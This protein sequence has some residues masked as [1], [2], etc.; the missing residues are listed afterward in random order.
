MEISYHLF[1]PAP[2]KVANNIDF[3]V[4]FG[5]LQEK[6]LILSVHWKWIVVNVFLHTQFS[7]MHCFPIY[8]H[9]CPTCISSFTFQT[10]KILFFPLKFTIDN[11][12]RGQKLHMLSIY[13][14]YNFGKYTVSDELFFFC[15]I[16]SLTIEGYFLRRGRRKAAFRYCH[17]FLSEKN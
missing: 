9:I 8:I 1:Q 16:R 4:H 10:K 2:P 5:W 17:I 13:K 11:L 12:Y 3:I 14:E 15:H 6:Q 7:Y